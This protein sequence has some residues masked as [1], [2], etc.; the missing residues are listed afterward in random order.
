MQ[1]VSSL[2]DISIK[3]L[4]TVR[5]G[6]IVETDKKAIDDL[7]EVYVLLQDEANAL[8]AYTKSKDPEDLKKYEKAG[9]LPGQKSRPCWESRKNPNR[10]LFGDSAGPRAKSVLRFGT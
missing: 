3:Q 4:K 1:E 9:R 2:A 5:N 8:S 10:P 6:N 7:I